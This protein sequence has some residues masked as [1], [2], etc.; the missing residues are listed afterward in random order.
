MEA[1]PRNR[2][3]V[4]FQIKKSK[5]QNTEQNTSKVKNG[6]HNSK[7]CCTFAP[8]KLIYYEEKRKRQQAS[9]E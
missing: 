6:L 7:K 1:D 8:E 5:R 2:S 9:N 3:R 4:C